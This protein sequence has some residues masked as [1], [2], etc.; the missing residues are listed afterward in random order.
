MHCVV[1]DDVTNA[2]VICEKKIAHVELTGPP[3][4]S[5]P[6]N[7]DLSLS[8]LRGRLATGSLGLLKRHCS[9][10]SLQKTPKVFF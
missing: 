6:A 1:N 2:N 10:K 7:H 3:T 9:I 5:G 4:R 8:V